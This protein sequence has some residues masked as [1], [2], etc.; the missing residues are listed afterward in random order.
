MGIC[1]VP[2]K[3]PYLPKAGYLNPA[4]DDTHSGAPFAEYGLY[5]EQEGVNHSLLLC[6]NNVILWR[7]Y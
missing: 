1:Y 7:I 5:I 6:C 4:A 2:Y 3:L